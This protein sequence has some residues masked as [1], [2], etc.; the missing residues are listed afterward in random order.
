M[1]SN[2][3]ARIEPTRTSSIKKSEKKSQG[4]KMQFMI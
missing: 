4:E 1:N 2:K 3:K